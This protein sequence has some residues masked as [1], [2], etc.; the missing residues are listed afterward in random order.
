MPTI[1]L[2]VPAHNEEECLPVFLREI[3][4]V[5]LSMKRSYNDLSFEVIVIDD[6][7]T[8]NTTAYLKKICETPPQSLF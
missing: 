3:N 5:A 2:V 7:S 8:D 4:S 1:S 6:G